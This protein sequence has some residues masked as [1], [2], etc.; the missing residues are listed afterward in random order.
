MFIKYELEMFVT[1][2]LS[3][4]EWCI[5]VVR[6]TFPLVDN[7]AAKGWILALLYESIPSFVET[8]RLKKLTCKPQ[9]MAYIYIYIYKDVIINESSVDIFEYNRVNRVII[10]FFLSPEFVSVFFFQ[11][12]FNHPT[13]FVF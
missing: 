4:G 2:C 5:S 9:F 3:H 12:C 11:L 7:F 8:V 6:S 10:G 13:Y 1:V